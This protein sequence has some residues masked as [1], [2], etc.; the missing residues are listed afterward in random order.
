[1]IGTHEE[2]IEP[3][4]GV[5]DIEYGIEDGKLIVS[6]TLSA[7]R[8]NFFGTYG[9]ANFNRAYQIFLRRK[10]INSPNPVA[11]VSGLLITQRKLCT[12]ITYS[13]CISSTDVT[14]SNLKPQDTEVIDLPGLNTDDIVIELPFDITP[15]FDIPEL[16]NE[17]PLKDGLKPSKPISQRNDF[18]FKK[19]IIRMIQGSMLSASNSPMRNEPGSIGYLQTKQFQKRLLQILPKDVLESPALQSEFINPKVKGNLTKDISLKEL[20]SCNEL[21]LSKQFGLKKSELL[22]IQSVDDK[23]Q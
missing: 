8:K 9:V 4:S 17:I 5:S 18:G 23:N 21:F 1:M 11:D 12:R 14:L 3:E 10:R 16:A 15:L 2:H 19:G 20:L 6:Y 22:K 7:R 13:D